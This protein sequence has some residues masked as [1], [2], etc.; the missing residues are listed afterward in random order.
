MVP[1]RPGTKYSGQFSPTRYGVFHQTVPPLARFQPRETGAIEG[2]D[3]HTLPD[4]LLT[5]AII[6]LMIF[7]A[8]LIVLSITRRILFIMFVTM[9]FT[10][11]KAEENPV[12]ISSQN[13]L[14]NPMKV[15][16][17][18]CISPPSTCTTQPHISCT[19]TQRPDQSPLRSAV[20]AAKTHPI[21]S[22]APPIAF[23]KPAR[24]NNVLFFI[25]SHVVATICCIPKK[26]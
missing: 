13:V 20:N 4:T 7:M 2:S 1:V 16:N 9:P 12:F 5:A 21:I 26:F 14:K 24:K 22:R 11:S 17:P 8:E 10:H 15:D 6:W 19:A 25:N 18:I 3:I 23:V